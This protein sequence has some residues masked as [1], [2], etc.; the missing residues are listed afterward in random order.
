MYNSKWVLFLKLSIGSFIPM[1]LPSFKLCLYNDFRTSLK[2]TQESHLMSFQLFWPQLYYHALITHLTLQR[3]EGLQ[4][5]TTYHL[6]GFL[7]RCAVGSENSTQRRAPKQAWA[8]AVMEASCTKWQPS[9]MAIGIRIHW[10]VR[11]SSGLVAKTQLL[12]VYVLL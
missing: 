3:T 7:T 6:Q 10:N 5:K 12:N 9:K 11:V 2:V 4:R 8:M 1:V